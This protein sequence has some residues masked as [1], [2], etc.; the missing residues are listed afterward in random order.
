MQKKR[1]LGMKILKKNRAPKLGFEVGIKFG[2]YGSSRCEDEV[3]MPTDAIPNF[4]HSVP[5]MG[6]W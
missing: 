4:E 6:T 3:D 1:R 2:L 5:E